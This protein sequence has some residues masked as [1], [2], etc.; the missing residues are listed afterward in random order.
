MI[1][2]NATDQRTHISLP[3]AYKVYKILHIGDFRNPDGASWSTN[4]E[5]LTGGATSYVSPFEVPH[6]PVQGL[7]PLQQQSMIQQP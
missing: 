4:Y 5:L 6:D 7:T 1:P 2:G 3:G